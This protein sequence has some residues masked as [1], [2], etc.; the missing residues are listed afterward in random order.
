MGEDQPRESAQEDADVR[1]GDAE[2]VFAVWSGATTLRLQC[3]KCNSMTLHK[4]GTVHYARFDERDP[5]KK[6]RHRH[7]DWT[8]LRCGDVQY[9]KLRGRYMRAML[10]TIMKSWVAKPPSNIRIKSMVLHD[11]REITLT[12]V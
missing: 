9:V 3:T 12:D 5:E 10:K 2:A 1:N 4:L 6:A 11:G 8:C 7:S